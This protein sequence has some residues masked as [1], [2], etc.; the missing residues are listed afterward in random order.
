MT[1]LTDDELDELATT[2]RRQWGDQLPA[3]APDES[4]VERELREERTMHVLH[5]TVLPDLAQARM[6]DRAA[7][8]TREDE[9]ALVERV[10]SA[11]FGLPKLLG[12]LRDPN[13]SDIVVMGA[14]PVR[15]ERAGGVREEL[16]PLVRRDRDLERVIYDVAAAHRRPFNRE[17]PFVDVELEPGVRFHGE[18]FDVVSRPL[19]TIRRAVA[20][21]ATL[22]E[23][24]AWGTVSDG[25]AR[26]LAAA[27]AARL[28]IL[29]AGEMGAGKTTLLRALAAEI[30][31]DDVVVT[32]ETDFELALG[33]LGRHRWV[34]AYQARLPSTTDAS[35][36]SCADM[37]TPALRTRADWI[38]VGEVRGAEAGA[39]VQAM[40]VGQGT[41]ATVHGGTA[42]DGLERVAALTSIHDGLD[43]ATARWQVHRAVDLVVH[44][45]GD[46]S[47]GRWISEIVVPSVEDGGGRFVLHTLYAPDRH[48]GDDRARPVS[49]PQQWMAER[50]QRASARFSLEPWRNGQD[51]Y[52][53][54]RGPRLRSVG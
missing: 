4:A 14:D 39:M 2:V 45:K 16:A 22:D 51:S 25:A 27:V 53:D 48:A 23:L 36:V 52:R 47:R 11:L 6:D 40:S 8:L 26:L 7:P 20:M 41:M 37:M 35:G 10:V 32:I 3:P 19:I 31:E 43:L 1:A 42:Q 18:G 13:V 28:S 21:R 30:P 29:V 12:V 5:H 49:E 54:L 50:L 44:L 38:I 46:N 17:A 24:R 34:H 33:G 9:D 15:V